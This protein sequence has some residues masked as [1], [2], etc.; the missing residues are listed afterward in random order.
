MKTR[1]LYLNA[2]GPVV[3]KAIGLRY[4]LGLPRD[5]YCSKLLEGQDNS[6]ESERAHF[7]PEWFEHA[8][9]LIPGTVAEDPDGLT[10]ISSADIMMWLHTLATHSRCGP[11]HLLRVSRSSS[12]KVG[13]QMQALTISCRVAAYLRADSKLKDAMCLSAEYLGYPKPW[14]TGTVASPAKQ[15]ISQ[16]RFTL[17]VGWCVV[18]R[19]RLADLLSS[20]KRCAIY[21]LSDSSP[22]GGKELVLSEVYIIV[23]ADELDWAV[24]ELVNM[25]RL[26]IKDHERMAELTAIQNNIIVSHAFGPVSLG[27]RTQKLRQKFSSLVFQSRFESSDRSMVQRLAECTRCITIDYGTEIGLQSVLCFDCGELYPFW[28]GE[29]HLANACDSA[30]TCFVEVNACDA[31]VCFPKSLRMSGME[32]VLHNMLAVATSKMKHFS[33]RFKDA[34]EVSQ[35]LR[36]RMYPQLLANSLDAAG[37]EWLSERLLVGKIQARYEKNFASLF[38]W[39]EGLMELESMRDHFDPSKIHAK[40]T[41]KAR[42][43]AWIDMKRVCPML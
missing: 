24:T 41:E 16:H 11:Q 22:H 4:Y 42:E 40:Y 34:K 43:E 27:A 7:K 29:A 31:I 17:D 30:G 33:E 35:M 18:W 9:A 13:C 23:D 38:K 19:R 10:H 39:L 6:K 15:T 28:L 2:S 3:K 36:R 26:G 32:H 20:G 14:V 5:K 37:T 8:A 25:K 12:N 21:L 1:L